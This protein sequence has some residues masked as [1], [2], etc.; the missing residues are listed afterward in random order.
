[1][2]YPPVRVHGTSVLTEFIVEKV[3][4]ALVRGYRL[5]HLNNW[6]GKLRLVQTVIGEGP[7]LAAGNSNGDQHLLQYASLA[8]GAPF[9]GSSERGGQ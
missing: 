6:D 8:E 3:E 2:T 4:A 1:M 5:Q 7:I 9:I